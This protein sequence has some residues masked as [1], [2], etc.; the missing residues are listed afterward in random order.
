[1]T[2]R[3]PQR[4]V[5]AVVFLAI[6]AVILIAVLT[7]ALS[8]RSAQTD[9]DARTIPVL[10]AAKEALL[11]YAAAN[12]TAPGRLPCVDANGDGVANNLDLPC[13]T[14]NVP[15]LGRLPWKTLGIP[16]LRDGSGECLWYAV[17]GN[18]AQT[19][20]LTHP[21][22]SNV[23]GQFTVKQ[24]PSSSTP[25]ATGVIAVIFAP[26]PVLEGNDRS[27]PAG[28]ATPCGGNNDPRQYLDPIGTSTNAGG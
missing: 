9:F 12:P 17:S 27:P 6:L 1:M 8:S 10:A 3:S 11:A 26:G 7:T 25:L 2:S 5:A 4:G 22:N 20:T 18:F 28:P 24:D 19:S 16:I 23:P 13:T 15:Q 21:I 14:A